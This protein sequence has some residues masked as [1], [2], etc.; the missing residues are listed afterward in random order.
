MKRFSKP[1]YVEIRAHADVGKLNFPCLYGVYDLGWD[2][3]EAHA[4]QKERDEVLKFD[5]SHVTKYCLMSGNDLIQHFIATSCQELSII[6]WEK[7]DD[8]V[9]KNATWAVKM[10]LC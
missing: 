7:R 6:S 4:R 10:E 2:N 9:M 1:N 8:E 3:P 5:L